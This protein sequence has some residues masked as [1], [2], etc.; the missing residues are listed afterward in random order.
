MPSG[1]S[2]NILPEPVAREYSQ[3]YHRL[4][5]NLLQSHKNLLIFSVYTYTCKELMLIILFFIIIGRWEAVSAGF[6]L[7]IIF[8]SSVFLSLLLPFSIH[9]AYNI[10]KK[11]FFPMNYEQLIS[12]TGIITSISPFNNDC[13]SQLVAIS[14]EEQEIHLTMSP[15]TMVV[16]SMPLLPGMR[17]AAFFDSMAPVPLI[18][19][20]QYRALLVTTLRAEEDVTL[21][22]FDETLTSSDNT[23]KL[24]IF[25]STFISTQNGQSYPCPLGEHYLMV[26]YTILPEASLPKPPLPE[27]LLCVMLLPG[28]LRCQIPFRRLRTSRN[29]RHPRCQIPF[30]RLRTSR[31][32]RHL[33]CQIPFRRLKVTRNPRHPRCQIL[34]RCLKVTRSPRWLNLCTDASPQFSFAGLFANINVTFA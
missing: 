19:P 10:I 4:F 16:D 11:D 6:L 8:L 24:N 26:Y 25:P 31:S 30:R 33:R 34:F 20:P 21:K 5:I 14:T 29:P 23:L 1:L 9:T 27:S 15:D 28:Q 2:L 22:Y 3:T 13:C 17:I 18:Y 7:F 12:V 32:P